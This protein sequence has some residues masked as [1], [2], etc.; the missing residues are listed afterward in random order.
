MGN[1]AESAR[2]IAQANPQ[3]DFKNTLA[4]Q[5]EKIAAVMPRHMSEERMYQLAVS[6]Y[7]STPQLAQCSIVSVLSCVMKCAALGLEPS[8]VDGLGR[9]YILPYRN[10]KTG[11]YEAQFIM[12]YKGMIDLAR[13]SKEIESISARAVYS[14]DEF[15]Y[16]YGLHEDLQHVPSDEPKEGRELTHAYCIAKFKDGGHYFNVLSREDIEKARKSSQ[17]GASKYSPWATHYEQMAV[18]TAIRRAFPY[19]PVSIE[20]QSAAASDETTPD[21]TSV[22]KPVVRDSKPVEAE[23]AEAV[24]IDAETAEEADSG[25]NMT[26]QAVCKTCGNVVFVTPDAT[27]QDI[28]FQCCEAPN[29]EIQAR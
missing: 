13:R 28:A 3:S 17:A 2:E 7:N 16:S 5:W 1:L 24:N 18:K 10:R 12:G 29:Y 27:A 21:Y 14:G 6:A 8:A 20:A 23:E 26:A 4:T 15:S 19:L 22:L 11:G 25:E 9:A